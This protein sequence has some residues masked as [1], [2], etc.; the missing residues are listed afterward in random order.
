MKHTPLRTCLITRERLPKNKLLRIV[1][2]KNQGVI[3]DSTGKMNGR[4]AYIKNDIQVIKKAKQ[5]KI[6]SKHFETDVHASLYET[7][8]AMCHD[9]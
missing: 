3:F 7:L 8:E 5:K 9:V 2:T 6:L 4:G 1:K